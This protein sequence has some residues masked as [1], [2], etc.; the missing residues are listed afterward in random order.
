MSESKQIDRLRAAMATLL[1]D[2]AN[3]AAL[4]EMDLV[5]GDAQNDPPDGVSD[6]SISEDLWTTANTMMDGFRVVNNMVARLQVRK[7]K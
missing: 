4:D 6:G 5:L 1:K 7:P 2:A 3:D